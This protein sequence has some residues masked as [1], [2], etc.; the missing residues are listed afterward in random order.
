MKYKVD[1]EY[2]VPEWAEVEIDADSKETATVLANVEFDHIYP[3][4]IDT[5]VIGVTEIGD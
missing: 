3:E 1:F 4:A 2:T 5:K